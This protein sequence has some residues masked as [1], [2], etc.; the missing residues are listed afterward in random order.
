MRVGNLELHPGISGEVGCDS[1]YCA[2]A[3][4]RLPLSAYRLRVTPSITLSTLSL[5]RIQGG[6]APPV[7]PSVMFRGGR[8]V[9]YNELIATD[10]KYSSEFS[11]QRHLDVGSD[12]LLNFSHRAESAPIRYLNFIRQGQPSNDPNTENAFDRD[13]VRAGAGALLAARWRSVRLAGRLRVHV[14]L[15]REIEFLESQ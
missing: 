7:R 9:S 10:S 2:C 4:R 8:H 14:Q 1:N 3:R 6:S 5:Q 13:S 15:L 12:I 11:D